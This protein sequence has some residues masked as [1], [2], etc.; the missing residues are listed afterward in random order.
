MGGRATLGRRGDFARVYKHGRRA[1]RDGISV[2][3][4]PG[5]DVESPTRL[6]LAIRARGLTAVARNRIK[7]RVRAAFS[8]YQPVTGFDVV[9]AATPEVDGKSY[10]Q[11]RDDLWAALTRTGIGRTA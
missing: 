7:R 10:Q 2:W 9:V 11:V 3:A 5:S 4:A 8:D 1:R 6:G